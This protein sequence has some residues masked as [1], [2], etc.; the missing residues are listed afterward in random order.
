MQVEPLLAVPGLSL[1]AKS[2][3]ALA[4]THPNH[5][6]PSVTADSMTMREIQLRLAPLLDRQPLG[7]LVGAVCGLTAS[8]T[9][10]WLTGWPLLAWLAGAQTLV[11]ASRL[12]IAYWLRADPARGNIAR[13]LNAFP[14]LP[15][16]FSALT[17]AIGA[18][19][20][21]GQA[22][23]GVQVL[24]VAS[25]LGLCGGASVRN[26][27]KPRI[28]NAQVVV[29]LVPVAIA[30]AAT[31]QPAL[32]VLAALLPAFI[33]GMIVVNLTLFRRIAAQMLTVDDSLRAARILQQQSQTDEVTGLANRTGFRS[34][35]EELVA[36]CSADRFVL[37]LRMDLKRFRAL[38]GVLGAKSGDRWQAEIAKRIRENSPENSVLARFGGGEFALACTADC[39]AEARQLAEGVIDAMGQPLRIDGTLIDSRVF[40]GAALLPPAKETAARLL[41]AAEQALA[42]AKA[43]DILQPV[44]FDSSMTQEK[45]HRRAL[46]DE[47]RG[48]IMR[49]ELSLHYQPII[50]LESGR[51]RAF[52]A[53]VRWFHPE[54]G[55]VP[56]S[57][58][59]PIAEE[60]GLIFTLSS[61]VIA[62]AAQAGSRWPDH[63]GLAVNLSPMQIR[64]PDAARGILTAL[65]EAGFDPARLVL[66][67]TAR[68]FEQGDADIVE[69][70]AEMAREGVGFALDDFGTG[71]SALGHVHRYPF[72]TIKVDRSFISGPL[73]GREGEAI[74]K[75]VVEMGKTLNMEVV[76]E[77][78]ETLEQ[79]NTVR[80]AGCTLGQGYYFSRP[81]PESMVTKLL[82]GE[83][84]ENLPLA[85]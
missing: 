5:E 72:S 35:L 34:R 32:L 28:A 57:K 60:T 56:P 12:I 37:L 6:L 62:K 21:I 81:V 36:D 13:A 44:F 50:D 47:L 7:L 45:E 27:G 46:E 11:A 69:F 49:D 42:H 26:A 19:V 80:Q 43:C 66:E 51:I 9:C 70:M 77:G 68:P 14:V 3:G 52:E 82:A 83:Q 31:G 10:A 71:S 53:L 39:A 33:L 78:L 67:I 74:I 76:A 29:T 63:L 18:Q 59:L 16:L 2:Q 22:E 48:A 38:N 64:T 65:H 85:V 23:A 79:V 20:L 58:F 17:G 75:A 40:A 24:G 84:L 1:H 73:L 30:C 54:Q 55:E 8:W 4:I 25:A 15:V 61:W 41:P